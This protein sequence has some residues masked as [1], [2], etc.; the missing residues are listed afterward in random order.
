MLR[1]SAST[2]PIESG[3]DIRNVRRLLGHASLSTNSL[4]Q[5]YTCVSDT[6]LR[7]M[8]TEADVLGSS[9]ARDN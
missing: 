9:L 7:R 3:V 4:Q 8:I 5:I 6:A 2:K 1:H